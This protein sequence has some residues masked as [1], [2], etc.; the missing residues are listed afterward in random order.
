MYLSPLCRLNN[1]DTYATYSMIS[2][3]NLVAIIPHV[4]GVAQWRQARLIDTT[5]MGISE[6]LGDTCLVFKAKDSCERQ[7]I[8]WYRSSANK[9]MVM[10][11]G[12]TTGYQALYDART[13]MAKSILGD[14]QIIL[15]TTTTRILRDATDLRHSTDFRELDLHTSIPCR[16]GKSVSYY[17]APGNKDLHNTIGMFLPDHECDVV[18][19]LELTIIKKEKGVH[20]LQP[21]LASQ[22]MLFLHCTTVSL[23]CMYDACM[24]HV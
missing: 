17:R 2:A 5:L 20:L 21:E 4:E 3:E 24:T 10:V 13:T 18:L 1:T 8:S 16:Y 11:S 23:I 15:R 9:E 19:P 7:L 6:L 22:D 12:L 14:A